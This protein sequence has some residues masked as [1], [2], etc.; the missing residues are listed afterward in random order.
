MA[1][2]PANIIHGVPHRVFLIPWAKINGITGCSTQGWDYSSSIPVRYTPK[3][4]L[5][6][7]DKE[8]TSLPVKDWGK[9][10]NVPESNVQRL[11]VPENLSSSFCDLESKNVKG[12]MDGDLVTVKEDFPEKPEEMAADNGKKIGGIQS[13]YIRQDV[14]KLAIELLSSRAFTAL[15]LRKKLRG[16]RYSSDIVDAVVTEFKIRG[17]INDGLYAEAYSRSRWSSSSWGPGRIRHE[18]FKKGVREAD[19]DKA[20]KQIFENDEEDDS[21]D[22]RIAMSKVSIDQL[23]F[24]A[25]KQW[26]QSNGAPHETRRTRIVR[27]LQYRGFNWSVTKYILKKLESEKS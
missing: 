5:K 13:A 16:K 1:F 22:P 25:A 12:K 7:S 4:S 24:K 15:E 17:L 2:S 9:R 6:N 8:I 23:Y 18:L 27:W 21:L 10:H 14:E 11:D 3:K 20:I 26:Q 19:A